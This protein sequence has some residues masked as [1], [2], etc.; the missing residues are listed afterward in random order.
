M[1]VVFKTAQL[2]LGVEETLSAILGKW[3]R[4]KDKGFPAAAVPPVERMKSLTM[5]TR[6]GLMEFWGDA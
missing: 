3:R 1:L 6:T 4:Q 5:L 2:H